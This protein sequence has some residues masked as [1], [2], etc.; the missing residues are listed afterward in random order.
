MSIVST[1][2]QSPPHLRNRLPKAT[3][4]AY[5]AF[6]SARIFAHLARCAAAILFLPAAEMW[7]IGRAFRRV[8]FRSIFA[9]G[10]PK[11]LIT[12]MPPSSPL[13]SS[14]TSLAVPPQFSSCLL[15]KCGRSEERSDVCSSDLSSQQ[16]PQSY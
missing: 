8:L 10:S 1:Q 13:V 2:T 16:A 15:L 4:H 9:T 11:L 14:P 3:N 12:P 5:A 6:F 7:Q